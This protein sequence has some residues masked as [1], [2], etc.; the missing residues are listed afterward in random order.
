M[1]C[2]GIDGIP[3]RV[4]LPRCPSVWVI[5]MPGWPHARIAIAVVG[6]VIGFVGFMPI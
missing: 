3:E 1:A 6:L 2:V 4:S 5:R